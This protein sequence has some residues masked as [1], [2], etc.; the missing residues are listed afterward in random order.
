MTRCGIC[1]AKFYGKGIEPKGSGLILPVCGKPCLDR[2]AEEISKRLKEEG[3][4]EPFHED[5]SPMQ[6]LMPAVVLV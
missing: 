1:G 3:I 6:D 5:E 4:E 2:K